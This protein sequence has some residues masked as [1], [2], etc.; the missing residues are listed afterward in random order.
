MGEIEENKL[1]F[2][3]GWVADFTTRVHSFCVVAGLVP[4]RISSTSPLGQLTVLVR[5]ATHIPLSSLDSRYYRRLMYLRCKL[6]HLQSQQAVGPN[7]WINND[8]DI[9]FSCE[10]TSSS[11]LI[12]II[13]CVTFSYEDSQ[14]YVQ[15]RTETLYKYCTLTKYILLL[16]NL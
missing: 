1:I 7:A 11:N 10:K 8:D 14:C 2:R 12:S 15:L 4:N 6:Q 13:Y 16:M 9:Y 3:C 5:F